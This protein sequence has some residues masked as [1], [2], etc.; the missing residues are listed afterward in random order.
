MQPA[1][2]L[3]PAPM[4]GETFAL[5]MAVLLLVVAWAYVITGAIKRWLRARRRG[6][7]RTHRKWG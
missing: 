4:T 3:T 5:W 1:S 7:Q 2:D 6:Y